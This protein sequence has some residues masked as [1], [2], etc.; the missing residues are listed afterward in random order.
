MGPRARTFLSAHVR[1][2][3]SSFPRFLRLRSIPAR[4]SSS[5]AFVDVGSGKMCAVSECW[6]FPFGPRA[7]FTDC[8]FPQ[9]LVLHG[10]RARC[11]SFLPSPP[12]GHTHGG[13]LPP[14]WGPSGGSRGHG[15]EAGLPV[16][17][18]AD[19]R[20]LRPARLPGSLSAPWRPPA[21]CC[22]HSNRCR[23]QQPGL[24]VRLRTAWTC[25]CPLDAP[26]PPG[27]GALACGSAGV[28]LSALQRWFLNL[29][30]QDTCAQS[31]LAKGPRKHLF[32]QVLSL[33]M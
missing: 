29:G 17:G 5:A 27:L 25:G 33:N 7:S 6:F 24:N 21:S 10:P 12:A 30:P 8:L 15:P 23:S 2:L 31:K 26:F 1:F 32:R 19:L 18:H 16:R 13:V 22:C 20:G 28:F 14:R 11:C 3:C 4:N 9:H